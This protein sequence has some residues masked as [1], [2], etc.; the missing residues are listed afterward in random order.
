MALIF[1]DAQEAFCQAIREGRLTE[2]RASW[3]WAGDW[4]YMGTQDGADLFK[5]IRTRGYL[6]TPKH[7]P[8]V[9]R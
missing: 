5:N 1:R 9:V 4:M 3:L 6:P 7:V 8:H 2:A